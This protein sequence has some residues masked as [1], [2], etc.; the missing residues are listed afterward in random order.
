MM[1]T[2]MV[3]KPWRIQMQN[4]LAKE[5]LR[6][7]LQKHGDNRIKRELLLFWGRHPNARFTKFA[8]CYAV[9][10]SGLQAEQS[11]KSH[12]EAGLVEELTNERG[13]TFYSLTDDEAK[14]QLIIELADFDWS[15]WNPMLRYY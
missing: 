5:D 9:D 14:R 15:Q 11:L 2:L 6:R 12:M 8:L 10:C 1:M 13:L 7:F 3:E 4:A